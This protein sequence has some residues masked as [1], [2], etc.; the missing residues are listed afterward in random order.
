MILNDSVQTHIQDLDLELRWVKTLYVLSIGL[1]GFVVVPVYLL[2]ADTG[3]GPWVLLGLMYMFSGLGITMGYHRLFSH[4][5]YKTHPVIENI[6]LVAGSMGLQDSTLN[7]CKKH[8]DHH[9]FT[10]SA[11]DPYNAKLGFLWSHVLW[12][13]YEP[14]SAPAEPRRS[15]DEETLVA[16][17]PN[18]KDL[19]KNPRVR[20]QHVY[21]LTVGNGLSVGVPIVVGLLAGDVL[22]YLMVAGFLRAA[23]F[24][25]CT[26]SVNSF[27]HLWGR[28]EYLNHTTA[29]DSSLVALITMGEGYHNYHHSQ[30]TD[31]RNGVKW[32]DY[33]PAKWVIALFHEFGWTWD[34]KRA[35]AA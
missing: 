14:K 8:R 24:Q 2:F 31:Y 9:A 11:K 10:D 1:L 30:P 23:I 7:W 19:V 6:L 4:K 5:T 22:G 29:R 13:F 28:Q 32:H 27:A 26:F 21:C 33:D 16:A 20:R 12:V 25:H 18:C 17:Y 35:A 15:S 34:L 3:A